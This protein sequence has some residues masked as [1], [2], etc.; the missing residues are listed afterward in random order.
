MSGLL[1]DEFWLRPC[2]PEAPLTLKHVE[3]WTA[4][5]NAALPTGLTEKLLRLN[6][7]EL[8]NSAFPRRTQDPPDWAYKDLYSPPFQIL[9]LYPLTRMMPIDVDGLTRVIEIGGEVDDA[10]SL[11]LDYRASPTPTVVRYVY[12]QSGAGVRGDAAVFGLAPTFD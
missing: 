11:C 2:W 12:P 7:G 4:K 9:S 8:R 3:D 5:W 1:S 10:Y 6:G